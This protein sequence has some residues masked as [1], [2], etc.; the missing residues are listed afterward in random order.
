MAHPDDYAFYLDQ[1]CED[2]SA[3]LGIQKM[4]AGYALMLDADRMYYFWL[5]RATGEISRIHWNRWAVYR[6]AKAV[7]ARACSGGRTPCQTNPGAPS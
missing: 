7:A 6:G 2:V 3:S 1:G 5:E 4:P